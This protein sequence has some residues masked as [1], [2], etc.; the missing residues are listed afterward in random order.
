ML[1]Y[2][3]GG[4]TPNPGPG[5]PPEQAPPEHPPCAVHAE[6]YGQQAGGMH[7]TRMQSCFIFMQFS[8]KFDR[9]ICCHPPPPLWK[10]VDPLL[11]TKRN[12]RKKTRR[13]LLA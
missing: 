6:R 2:P 8:R 11:V 12:T 9:I 7:P 4:D 10:I 3:P 13:K 1:G 5:P